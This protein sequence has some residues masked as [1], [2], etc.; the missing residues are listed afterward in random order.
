MYQLQKENTRLVPT[1]D[2]IYTKQ[3]LMGS[4][5]TCKIDLVSEGIR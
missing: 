4:Y 1:N 2:I 5:F 3:R